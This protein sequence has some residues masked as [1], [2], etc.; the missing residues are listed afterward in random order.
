MRKL[1]IV[2]SVLYYITG[3]KIQIDYIN[4]CGRIY[5]IYVIE[6]TSLNCGLFTIAQLPQNGDVGLQSTFQ[7]KQ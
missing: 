5:Y 4:L 3:N 6:I 1:Y 2:M 7:L